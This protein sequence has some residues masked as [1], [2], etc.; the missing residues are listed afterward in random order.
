VNSS[1]SLNKNRKEEIFDFHGLVDK[2]YGLQTFMGKRTQSE[3]EFPSDIRREGIPQDRE[4][5]LAG[6]H[7]ISD[8]RVHK[9]S[10]SACM[11]YSICSI[12]IVCTF[13]V[14]CISINKGIVIHT[15]MHIYTN[16]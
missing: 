2:L 16:A 13:M 6:I 15:W 10:Y 7:C 4:C 1:N 12:H 3:R 14:T 5:P 8:E 11:H 9:C